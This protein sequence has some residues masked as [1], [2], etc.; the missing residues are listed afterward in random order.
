MKIKVKEQKD[1]KASSPHRG[2]LVFLSILFVIALLSAVLGYDFYRVFFNPTLVKQLLVDEVEKTDLVPAVFSN[3][4]MKRAEERI[5]KG[6]A[7]SGV[8]EPDIPLLLSFMELE[9]WRAIK[10][11]ILS[12]EFVAH[13]VSVSVDGIYTW[14]DSKDVYPGIVWDMRSLKTELVGQ[15]GHDAVMVGY[16]SLPECT[17]DDIWDFTTRLAAMPPGVEV[18]YN[19]CQ[20]PDPWGEDQ[21]DDY[22]HALEDVNDNI[23]AEYDFSKMLLEGQPANAVIMNLVKGFL[24]TLRFMGQWGWTIAVGLLGLVIAIGVRSWKTLG[25]WV[26]VPLIVSGVILLV[27]YFLAQGAFGKLLGALLLSQASEVVRT[28]IGNSLTHLLKAFFQP[29]L[30]QSL[31]ILGVGIMLLVLKIVLGKRG[32]VGQAPEAQPEA[33]SEV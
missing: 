22:V 21:I 28:E 11:L 6:E 12:D 8:S 26:G 2:L 19:L 16:N 31:I 20:F 27:K 15:Q 5:E 4:S 24:K 18:L 13:L 29:M 9:D 10:D 33:G 7:L 17:E 23:P 25:K 32:K 1:K 30:T 3:F 14:L